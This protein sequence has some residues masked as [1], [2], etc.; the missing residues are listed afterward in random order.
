MNTKANSY[1]GEIDGLRAI[2]VIWVILYHAFPSILPGGFVGVD[3]FFVISGYLITGLLV[4]DLEQNQFS[5]TQFYA[6]RIRRIFPA[7]ILVIL[8]VYAFGWIS[9][10]SSEFDHIGFKNEFK[11]LGL[12]VVSGI[13]FF[14]N[15]LLWHEHSYFDLISETKPLL[16]LWSLGIEEQFYILFPPLLFLVWKLGRRK[17]SIALATIVTLSFAWNIY[18]SHIDPV[19]D[20]YSPLTRAWEL[21]AGS[22]LALFQRSHRPVKNPLFPA[23]GLLLILASGIF[24]SKSAAYPS[25]YAL[26]P[27][28]GATALLASSRESVIHRHLLASRPLVALGLISYPLYLWHWPVLSYMKIM[29]LT[30]TTTQMILA[31]AAIT[32]LAWLTYMCIERPIRFGRLRTPRMIPALVSGAAALAGLGFYT[33]SENGIPEREV[34]QHFSHKVEA[35]QWNMSSSEKCEEIYGETPDPPFCISNSKHPSIFLLGDSHANQLFGGLYESFHVISAGNGAPIDSV[36]VGVEKIEHGWI[37]NLNSWEKSKNFIKRRKGEIKVVVLSASWEALTNGDF[38]PRITQE[39]FGHIRLIAQRPDE[40]QLKVEELFER[41]LQRTIDFIH[42]QGAQVILALE[43]PEVPYE[44]RDCM[45]NI[46]GFAKNCPKDI[47]KSSVLQRQTIARQTFARLAAR[48]PGVEVFDPL[49]AFCDESKCRYWD[50]NGIPLYRD[51][52]HISLASSKRVGALLRPVIQR[53]Y[54]QVL[55][56][57]PSGN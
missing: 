48:N 37:H 26:F 13:S 31:L 14:A 40:S 15:L 42:S 11:Q 55:A 18:L 43:P 45:R 21:L 41:G 33:Y 39:S 28:A 16:H 38:L 46:L 36:K 20:F 8:T 9:L 51:N 7:L 23:V 3:I 25:W 47:A 49:D 32:L 5:L 1:R 35:L 54:N 12:H 22:W 4:H 10:L 27:V 2:A 53:A 57:Y 17:T 24:L 29:A 56:R 6:R 34:N 30:P 19:A 52:N 50:E 44:P